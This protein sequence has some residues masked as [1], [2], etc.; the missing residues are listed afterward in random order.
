MSRVALIAYLRWM[1]HKIL[2]AIEALE[3]THPELRSKG[4]IL[5]MHPRDYAGTKVFLDEVHGSSS[6][7]LTWNGILIMPDETLEEGDLRVGEK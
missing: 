2:E 3:K 1:I 5:Y 4:M 7:K 6:D